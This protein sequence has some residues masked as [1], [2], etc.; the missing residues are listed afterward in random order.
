MV[1][2]VL[3][4]LKSVALVERPELAGE[5]K[6]LVARPPQAGVATMAARPQQLAALLEAKVARAAR[7]A[8]RE[9]IRRHRQDQRL[10]V[11]PGQPR[12][13]VRWK[14]RVRDLRDY[15]EEGTSGIHG[16]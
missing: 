12:I 3:A 5:P 4:A 11:V 10:G 13:A 1:E 14:R 2:Q 15:S 7:S 6:R 16:R 9:A 8:A